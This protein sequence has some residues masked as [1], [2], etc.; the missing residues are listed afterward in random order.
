MRLGAFSKEEMD[1]FRSPRRCSGLTLVELVVVILILGI[2]SATVAPRLFQQGRNAADVGL[3]RTLANIRDAI[4]LFAADNDGIL[5]G[6]NG[7]QNTFKNDLQPY[8][9]GSFPVAPVGPKKGTDGVD[10]EDEGD[11]LSGD[12]EPEDAWV[13]DYTTGE[14]LLNF[15]GLSSDGITR[16]D[17]F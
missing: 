11:P 17:E 12:D 9:R 13:Y 5:P 2:L 14:F 8:L 10:M 15:D 16:Y 7:N 6:A 3:R 1:F 4:D